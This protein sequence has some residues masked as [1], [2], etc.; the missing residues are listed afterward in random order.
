MV[1]VGLGA[2]GLPQQVGDLVR[3]SCGLQESILWSAR[4]EVS[5]PKGPGLPLGSGKKSRVASEAGVTL[6]KV[7]ATLEPQFPSM[8]TCLLAPHPLEQLP[9]LKAWAPQMPGR[10]NRVLLCPFWKKSQSLYP[11]L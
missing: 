2:E 1:G 3:G 5:V 8:C 10:D 4:F 6:G 11:L 7:P 9:L